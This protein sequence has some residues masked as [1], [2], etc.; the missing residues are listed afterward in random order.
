VIERATFVATFK[1]WQS[2]CH[3]YVNSLLVGNQQAVA[4]IV[5]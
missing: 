4:S 5:R 3:T 1:H 2:Q